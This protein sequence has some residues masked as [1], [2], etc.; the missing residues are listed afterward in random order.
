[1]NLIDQFEE[2]FN[3]TLQY[4]DHIREWQSL[5]NLFLGELIPSNNP[6][7]L[8]DPSQ[9]INYEYLGELSFGFGNLY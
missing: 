2:W 5:E 6:L 9:L 1:M 4:N 7:V 3:K 8:V